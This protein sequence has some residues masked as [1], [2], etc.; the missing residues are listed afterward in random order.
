VLATFHGPHEATAP[1]ELASHPPLPPLACPVLLCPVLLVR[2]LRFQA[3][4]IAMMTRRARFNACDAAALP[5][6]TTL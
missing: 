3:H 1:I 6:A 4:Q 2:H 5:L